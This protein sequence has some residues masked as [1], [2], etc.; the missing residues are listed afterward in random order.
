MRRCLSPSPRR[1]QAF[2]LI[3][4]LVVIAIIAILIGLLLPAVQKV[5]EAAARMQCSNNLKQLGLAWHN[6]HDTTGFFP[7]GGQHWSLPPTY[8]VAVPG[9]AQ[10][11][12]APLASP[13]DV[14]D[15]RAGWG[16]QILPYIEQDNVYR[17]SGAATIGQAQR[18]AQGAAIKT[19]YC[20]SR[21]SPVVYNDTAVPAAYPPLSLTP[22]PHGQTDYAASIA[23]NSSD[24]GMCVRTFNHSTNGIPGTKRREPIRI[25]EVTDGLSN[26]LMIGDKRLKIWT[27]LTFRSDDN[28]G[29]TAGWDHDVIRR[30]DIIPAAD[31][32]QATDPLNA[33]NT[34]GGGRFGGRHTGGFN[35][36][37]GDGSVRFIPYTIDPIIFNRLGHR[38]DGEVVGNY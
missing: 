1:H 21:R 24:N 4:L 8:G 25:A 26:T 18:I 20:P 31:Y 36:A 6:H 7:A 11:D 19:F 2:T 37:L 38:S 13:A 33:A 14:R 12:S 23:N 27:N 10:V 3:E 17:G 34:H 22:A 5:R 28:E 15:Q 35:A 29:F 9:V 30:T 32:T 16:F